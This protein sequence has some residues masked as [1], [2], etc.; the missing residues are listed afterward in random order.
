MAQ[1]EPATPEQLDE[2]RQI[3]R[4]MITSGFTQADVVNAVKEQ[5]SEWGIS[6]RQVRNYVKQVYEAMSADAGLVDRA[7]YFV[8][9]IERI[10]HVYHKA[11][12]AGNLKVAQEANMGIVKLLKLDTPSAAM[13]WRKVAKEAGLEDGEAIA[14]MVKLFDKGT[15]RDIQQ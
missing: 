5:Y 12:E 6:D 9:T 4:N 7:A 3:I 1:H 14:A 2:R 11:I 10:D 8:R 15:A 13:D